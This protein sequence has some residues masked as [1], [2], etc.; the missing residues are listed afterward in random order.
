MEKIIK[1]HGLYETFPRK[2]GNAQGATHYCA[3]CGHGIVHKLVG[4]AM[5]DLG[6]Q[7]RTVIISPVGCAVF[8]YYYFDCGNIQAAHGRA[9]AVAAAVSRVEPSSAV[10][11]YQGDG[12]L[13]S[14]GFNQTFQAANRGERMAIIFVN[15]GIY[16][17]TGGQ[18]APTTLPGQKTA[19][20][21]TG[22]DT[23][24]TGYPIHVS[25]LFNQLRAPVY[26]ERC[27]VADAKRVMQARRAI[28]H[29]IEIQRDGKGFAFV[30]ILSPGPTCLH[31]EPLACAEYFATRMEQ[32]FPLGKFRDNA[33]GTPAPTAP[34]KAPSLNEFFGVTTG[35]DAGRTA[36]RANIPELRL[37]VAGHGGQGI[38]RL[39][40]LAAE[41]AQKSGC[42]A[43]WYPSYGPEQRG[44]DSSCAVVISG[45]PVGSPVVAEPDIL[46]AMNQPSVNRFAETVVPG[47]V[48][49]YEASVETPP[50]RRDVR[51]I[52]VPALSIADKAGTAQSA[53]TAMIAALAYHK[54]LPVTTEALQAAVDAGFTRKPAALELNR[55]VFADTLKWCAGQQ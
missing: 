32:E 38:L 48:I 54:L 29:A 27:S 20:S 31:M 4:E 46:V 9:A 41:A 14:I 28:R 21:P 1:S 44:G 22:R 34:E 40:L 23:A 33:A 2:G 5:A 52:P 50:A 19:T 42:S 25:E 24:G 45:A 7:D 12:D 3:G 53:N 55:K 26:I 8:G 37:K 10:I 36:T 11:S 15:N 16:G 6:I 35:P 47:G 17:M 39:G 49:L 18:L 30:E 51:L 13:A 43:S